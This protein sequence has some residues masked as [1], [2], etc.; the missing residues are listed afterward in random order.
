MQNNRHKF[1]K[2]NKKTP[3]NHHQTSIAGQERGE[4]QKGKEKKKE[5]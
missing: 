3:P 1:L 4:K 2:Q 5:A